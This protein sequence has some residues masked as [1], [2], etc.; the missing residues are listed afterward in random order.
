MIPF[1][2]IVI[3][4]KNIK[5][6]IY[7]QIAICII[8]AIRNGILKA[9]A[10]LPGSR[11]LAKILGVHRKTVIAAYDELYAQDWI[12][13]VP[14]K[15]VAVSA[16]IP[17]LKPHKWSQTNPSVSYENN[18]NLP[19]KI[20]EEQEPVNNIISASEIIIDDGYPDIGLSPIDSLLKTYRSLT[21]RKQAIKNAHS[22][23]AQGTLELREQL[24]IYL[25]ETRGLNITTD[26]IIITHGAQM[27]IYLSSYLILNKN[28]AIIVAR[29]NY[30]TANSAF[31]ETGAKIIEVNVDDNGIDVNAV[32]QLCKNQKISAVYVIPHHHYPTT[33]TLSVE[34]RM[35]LLELSQ[36]FSFTIIEDDYDY[37][38]HYSSSP[39]LPLASAGHSGNIIYIGSFSKMLDPSIRIGFMLAPKNFI[40]QSVALRNAI[41]A[42]GDGYMQNALAIMI[43][44]GELKRHLKKAK[45]VYQQRRDYL[46]SLLNKELSQY[47]SYQLPTGGMAIWIKLLPQYPI[48]QLEVMKG[49]KIKTINLEQNAF[50]F[51][52]ASMNEKELED[53]VHLLSLEFKK[54]IHQP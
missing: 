10:H 33:V 7:R 51:G 20:I 11:E 48:S 16:H 47:I 23:T 46:D 42:G 49:L 4:D 30:P 18:F 6:P 31:K 36:V 41:D 25:S 32:E 35:K 2:R 52:F 43:K 40:T 15:Y 37:D 9:E 22:N 14:K 24:V 54:F 34:R 53:V 27:S 21:L 38:Y 39:Y 12:I 26:N 44:E 13:I 5:N 8:N 28:A 1:D 45:K 50:R 19:L 29:P 3:I 17:S